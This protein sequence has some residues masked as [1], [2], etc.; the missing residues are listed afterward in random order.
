MCEIRLIFVLFYKRL[1]FPMYIKDV[2]L[3]KKILN[4]STKISEKSSDTMEIRDGNAC[5]FQ[6]K[7]DLSEE[8]KNLN[9]NLKI[10]NTVYGV[11]DIRKDRIQEVKM[12]MSNK[13]YMKSIDYGLLV[14]R[15]LNFSFKVK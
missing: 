4:I 11:Q 2:S 5:S 10:V 8:S 9:F 6:D 1:L 13:N 3:F 15:I 7:V 12:K 14:D